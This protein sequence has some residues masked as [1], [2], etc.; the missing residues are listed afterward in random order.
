[1]KMRY[2]AIIATM[3]MFPDLVSAG[4]VVEPANPISDMVAENVSIIGEIRAKYDPST[5]KDC[6]PPLYTCEI[7]LTS[8]GVVKVYLVEPTQ[9][10]PGKFIVNTG[11]P[12][13]QRITIHDDNMNGVPDR[14]DDA[15][16]DV[17]QAEG[18][19]LLHD[20]L[21]DIRQYMN[22]TIRTKN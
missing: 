11:D 9:N 15:P 5:T 8:H 6:T 4:F 21:L 12:L 22:S 14:I 17:S 10:N 2:I 1:M 19:S 16:Y 3:A 18:V 20:T 7:M 13:S